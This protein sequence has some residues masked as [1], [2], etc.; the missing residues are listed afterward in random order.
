MCVR[1]RLRRVES[2][3][4]SHTFPERLHIVIFLLGFLCVVLNELMCMRMSQSIFLS[5]CTSTPQ[6]LTARAVYSSRFVDASGSGDF[7]R[8]GVTDNSMETSTSNDGEVEMPW[9]A[10]GAKGMQLWFP[11]SLSQPLSP[12]KSPSST[13]PMDIE[14]EFDREV[15]H[16]PVD[17]NW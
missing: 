15:R 17:M 1:A 6:Q 3:R 14:L 7:G 13:A 16:A 11:S 4:S 2:V 5:M 9:W 10:Y 12:L 8:V